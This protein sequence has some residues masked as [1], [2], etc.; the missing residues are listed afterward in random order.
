MV[1][2][3]SKQAIVIRQ[4]SQIEILF[5]Q[6]HYIKDSL[7]PGELYAKLPD[8]DPVAIDKLIEEVLPKMK[9][10][11]T[12]Q[13]RLEQ[14]AKVKTGAGRLMGHDTTKGIVVMTESASELSDARKTASVS[15][16]DAMARN[17]P[18]RIHVIHPEKRIR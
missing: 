6:E 3:T 13:E 8:V 17:Q 2:N 12:A 16:P 10:G 11:Q 1:K 18:D 5:I 9:A 7:T 4:P 15:S 14:L